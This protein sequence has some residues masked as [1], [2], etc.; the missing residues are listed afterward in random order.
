MF[1]CTGVATS[2]L[3]G[4]GGTKVFCSQALKAAAADMTKAMREA[5]AALCKRENIIPVPQLQL[6]GKGAL[7]DKLSV[8]P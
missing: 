8:R 4:G 1:F 2:T 7:S 6:V 3:G 5:A